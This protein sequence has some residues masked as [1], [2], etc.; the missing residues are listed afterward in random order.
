MPAVS[1]RRLGC[2]AGSGT[3]RPRLTMVPSTSRPAS[4]SIARSRRGSGSAGRGRQIPDQLDARV[5]GV[6]ALPARARG[7]GEPPA[8][9]RSP[10]RTPIRPGFPRATADR[11]R[12]CRQLHQTRRRTVA[13]GGT[14]R[15]HVRAAR[16]RRSAPRAALPAPA[17]AAKTPTH[18]AP[19]KGTSAATPVAAQAIE[20]RQGRPRRQAHEQGCRDHEH[21]SACHLH[22]EEGREPRASREGNVLRVRDGQLQGRASPLEHLRDHTGRCG[23]CRRT[24]RSH[25]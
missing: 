25:G 12:T 5:G 22:R 6:H 9:A 3:P 16:G 4:W 11:A 17:T 18:S 7:P 21:C 14:P 13:T 20:G 2:G 19:V 1:G 24:G 23:H 15:P 8:R 10:G